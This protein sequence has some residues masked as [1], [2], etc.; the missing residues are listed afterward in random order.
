[1]SKYAFRNIKD[2]I[3]TALDSRGIGYINE[4]IRERVQSSSNLFLYD[5][6]FWDVPRGFTFPGKMRI[7][8]AW[9]CLLVRLPNYEANI[10]GVTYKIPIKPFWNLK[11]LRLPKN[12]ELWMRNNYLFTTM[13]DKA[14]DLIIDSVFNI[15]ANKFVSASFDK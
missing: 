8:A 1:M 7:K 11:L 5:C 12:L 4:I 6:K 14:P 2:I 13:I 3:N 9:N 10:D 15:T